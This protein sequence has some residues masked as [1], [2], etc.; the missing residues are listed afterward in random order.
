M[1][2]S[3]TRQKWDKAA[4]HFDLMASKGG[5]RRWEPFKKA[6]FSNMDGKILFLALGT[7]L[8]IASFPPGKNITAIDISPAMLALARPR[9]AAY[10]GDIEALVMDVHNLEF[11]DN[12]FDQV[13]T[14]CTFCSVPDPVAGLVSLK[15]VLKPGGELFMFEHTGSRY[16]PFKPMMDLMTMVSKRLGPDMNRNTV[17]NVRAAGFDIVEVNNL[18]LDVVKTIKAVK[19][20]AAAKVIPEN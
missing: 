19:P 3:A 10:Q 13:F 1:V 20:L 14:S 4:K 7:G 2:D 16:Y 15:R 12:S 6:L 17:E 9:L 18:F 5:E 11:A 8:D